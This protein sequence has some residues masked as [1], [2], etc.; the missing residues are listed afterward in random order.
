MKTKFKSLI[1]LFFILLGLFGLAGSSQAA[2]LHI[3]SGQAYST[4]GAAIAASSSGDTV[5]VHSGTYHEQNLTPKSGIDNTH[6]T[7]II[8][9]AGE[10]MP[11]I[12]AQSGNGANVITFNLSGNNITLSGLAIRGGGGNEEYASVAIGASGSST[13]ITVEKCKISETN[14][15]GT[16]NFY[17]PAH[18]RVGIGGT[19]SN[20]NINN[21]EIFGAY[22]SGMKVDGRNANTVVFENNYIHN[23][24]SGI[25]I[26]WGDAAN[27]GFIIRYNKIQTGSE[28]ALYID[29]GFVDIHDNVGDSFNWGIVLGDNY[30]GNNC[31][32]RHNTFYGNNGGIY[33]ATGYDNTVMDNIIYSSNSV[34]NYGSG[35]T[36]TPNF[37][38]NPLFADAVNHNF[39]LNSGS[40][41]HNTASDGTDYGANISLV[42]VQGGSGDIISPASPSGLSVN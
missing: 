1:I 8:G 42:G 10:A 11:I 36:T 5:I 3:G 23:V 15:G 30:Y 13:N 7:I 24:A 25:A 19:I 4:V 27:R 20:I 22:A 6:R 2:T 34:E 9:A 40:G 29:Q 28:R 31:I 33:I 26:K 41:A 37:T 17:N 32:V 21:N 35:N 39:H 14:I 16:T 38:S 12:D 18:I